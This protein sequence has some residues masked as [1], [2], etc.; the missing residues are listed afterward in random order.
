MIEILPQVLNMDCKWPKLAFCS[1]TLF[2]SFERWSKYCDR[3]MDVLPSRSLS[4]SRDWKIWI[5][6]KRS[7]NRVLKMWPNDDTI[8]LILNEQ[9]SRVLTDIGL[10]QQS[11]FRQ[12]EWQQPLA[13]QQIRSEYNLMLTII[14]QL[15]IQ[16]DTVVVGMPSGNSM[17]VWTLP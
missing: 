10:Q 5:A 6:W 4:R 13:M 15:L 8:H 7:T 17:S 11:S 3:S 1:H 16:L 2:Y 12:Y 9:I 14:P